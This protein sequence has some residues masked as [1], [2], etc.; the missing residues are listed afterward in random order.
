MPEEENNP[1]EAYANWKAPDTG[2]GNIEQTSSRPELSR[3]PTTNDIREPERQP[4]HP[5]ESSPIYK[6]ILRVTREAMANPTLYGKSVEKHFTPDE[7]PEANDFLVSTLA[8]LNQEKTDLLAKYNDGNRERIAKIA[9]L[10]DDL[11]KVRRSVS[12][13]LK[14]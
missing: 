11:E 10:V 14:R 13:R 5:Y 9:R 8:D 12:S 7:L 2:S 6:K 1:R 4:Q 3:L